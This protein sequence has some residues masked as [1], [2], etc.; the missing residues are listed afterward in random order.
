MSLML[1]PTGWL[2]Q[3]RVEYGLLNRNWL[4]IVFRFYELSF[5]H[6]IFY[7]HNITRGAIRQIKDIFAKVV[8]NNRLLISGS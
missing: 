3:V 2:F 1:L 8:L 7:E 4:I 6:F 5:L